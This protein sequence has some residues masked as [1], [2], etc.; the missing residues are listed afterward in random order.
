MDFELSQDHKVLQT[1]VRDF[2]EKEIKPVAVQID[3]EHAIPDALLK[4]IGE[5]GFM[6][7]F[8]PEEYG[9]AGLDM[10]S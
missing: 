1:A 10:L 4:K 9:G 6:G 7:S 8:F 2:V 3:Q 5:M